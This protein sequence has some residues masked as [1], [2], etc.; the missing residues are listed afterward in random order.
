MTT[1][2]P[3]TLEQD[4]DVLRSI[5]DRFD[6]T[7]ALNCAVLRGGELHLGDSVELID[8]PWMT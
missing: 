3:D 8:E 1:F 5:P 2:D 4:I 6:G 7:F